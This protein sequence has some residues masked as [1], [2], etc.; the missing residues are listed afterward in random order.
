M[1]D[2]ISTF[3]LRFL[4]LEMDEIV[5]MVGLSIL[6]WRTLCEICSRFEVQVFEEEETP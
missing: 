5:F 1:D 3:W 6:L 2:I 4:Q